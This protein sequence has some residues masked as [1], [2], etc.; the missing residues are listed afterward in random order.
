VT[1]SWLGRREAVHG[2]AAL[3]SGI[4]NGGRDPSPEDRSGLAAGDDDSVG[5]TVLSL[6]LI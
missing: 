2:A 6:L 5:L 3:Q 4:R 1:D